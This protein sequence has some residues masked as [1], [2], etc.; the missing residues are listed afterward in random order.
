VAV[1]AVDEHMRRV[2]VVLVTEGH[3]KWRS[4]FE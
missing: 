3:R 2:R 1:Y 4:V